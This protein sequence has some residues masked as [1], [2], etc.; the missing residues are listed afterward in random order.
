MLLVHF[1]NKL[2]FQIVKTLYRNV[3]TAYRQSLGL[4]PKLKVSP[5]NFKLVRLGTPGGGWSF[6][7][8]GKLQDSTIVSCGLGED[9]SFDIE[10]AAKYGAKVVIV[11]PT[12]RSIKHFEQ[13]QTRIGSTAIIPYVPSGTQPVEA[14]DLS[15]LKKD[16]LTLVKKALWIEAKTLKFFMPKNPNHVSH[17]IVNYQNNYRIDTDYIDVESVT[18]DTLCNEAQIR[19]LLLIKLDIEGAE[20][21]VLQYMMVKGIYPDQILVEYDELAYPSKRS[22]ARILLA[23]ASL[24]NSGYLLINFEYPS[25]LLYVR[26]TLAV[27]A[28]C[29]GIN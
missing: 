28:S 19:G 21:E 20:I 26:S 24:V 2:V 11:D 18:L 9:A 13:V 27:P 16:S 12:P 14:Y 22:K 4:T 1:C 3:R 5:N 25:N 29:R 7:D 8:T 15:K 10:F 6:V 17:S 23:H